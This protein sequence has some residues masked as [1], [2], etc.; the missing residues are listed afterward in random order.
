MDLAI[1]ASLNVIYLRLPDTTFSWSSFFEFT[2]NIVF[3][4][5]S[6]ILIT[7]PVFVVVF[8]GFNFKRWNDENFHKRYGALYEGLKTNKVMSLAYLVIFLMRRIVLVVVVTFGD[9]L[10][11]VQIITMVVF[12]ALQVAYLSTFKPN[13]A[14]LIHRLNIFNEVTT[15]I[16]VDMLYMFELSDS[17]KYA[18]AKTGEQEFRTRADVSFLTILNTNLV[19]HIFFLLRSSYRGVKTTC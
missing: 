2:N 14:T 12:S 11:Y 16:L 8:Y 17:E 10:L 4:S 18:Y 5:F 9:G 19:V 3:L 1:S 6:A 15:V 13:Q 7:F